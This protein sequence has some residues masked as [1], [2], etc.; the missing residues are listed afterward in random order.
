MANAG[1]LPQQAAGAYNG[2]VSGA[3]AG[4]GY[5]P[6]NVSAPTATANTV[7]GTNLNPYMNPYR[8]QVTNTVMNDLNRAN[9]MALDN[10]G[11]SATQANAFGGSRHGVAEAETNRNFADVTASTLAGLNRNM[12]NTALQTAGQDVASQNQFGLANQA[13]DMQSQL[14][15]QQAGLSG[16]QQQLAGAGLLGSLG[17]Q[18]Y[19]MAQGINNQQMQ[20]GL[21][22]Q[23]L[24][25]QVIDAGKQQYQGWSGAPAQGLNY[26]LA[27]SGSMPNQAT[28]STSQSPGLFDY[29]SA[30][31]SIAATP[32]SGGTSLLGM[33]L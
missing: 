21:L 28:Q 1:A 8:E 7:A 27:A 13:A 16:N 30:G 24:Q 12:F 22:Q 14:A 6:M 32:M 9:Q 31:A 23:A 26:R 3:A 4:M 17:Q 15:N 19:D 29:L 5:Q 2:A 11:S 18:G 25:Q 20:Y 10:V 33:F